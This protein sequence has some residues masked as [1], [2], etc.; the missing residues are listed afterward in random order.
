MKK[1]NDGTVEI[2]A[3]ELAGL[4]HVVEESLVLD[5]GRAAARRVE[6]ASLK[7]SGLTWSKARKAAQNAEPTE[8]MLKVIRERLGR[9]WNNTDAIHAAVTASGLKEI[10]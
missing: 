9:G 1:L 7:Q 10:K 5:L 4:R 8:E 3:E 2:S 6:A